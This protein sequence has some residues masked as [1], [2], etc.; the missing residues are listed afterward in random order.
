MEFEPGGAIQRI[1]SD[2]LAD[3]GQSVVDAAAVQVELRGHILNGA[4]AVVKQ[5]EHGQQ[6]AVAV[7]VL[8]L[9]EVH[10]TRIVPPPGACSRSNN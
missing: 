6:L 9:L 8:D 7:G 3:P 5:F 1:R 10:G 4:V 2:K